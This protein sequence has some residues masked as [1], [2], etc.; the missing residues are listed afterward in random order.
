[1]NKIRISTLV[2]FLGLALLV[3]CFNAGPASAQVI[4]GKF[5]LPFEAR[6]GQAT[7]PAGDY[8]F[9]LDTVNPNCT[10]RLSRERRVVAFIVSQA[11]DKNGSGHAELT[12]VR[13]TVRALRLPEIGVILEYAPQHPEHLTANEEREISQI[14]PITAAGKYNAAL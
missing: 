14:V 8:S 11:Q 1:M 12:V 3:V 4:R 6:W 10:L 7:L 13:G 5:T 9:T 2:R